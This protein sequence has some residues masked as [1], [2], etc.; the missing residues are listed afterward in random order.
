MVVMPLQDWFRDFS[1]KESECRCWI[2]VGNAWDT[3]LEE[4]EEKEEGWCCCIR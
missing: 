1:T 3:E 4:E 2:E